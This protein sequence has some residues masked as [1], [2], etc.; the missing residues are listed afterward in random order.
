MNS[1]SHHLW[2]ITFY[3]LTTSHNHC[4]NGQKR[5][6]Q[7]VSSGKFCRSSQ[8]KRSKTYI[9]LFQRQQKTPSHLLGHKSPTT[10]ALYLICALWKKIMFIFSCVYRMFKPLSNTWF[11]ITRIYSSYQFGFLWNH[12]LIYSATNHYLYFGI[13]YHSPRHL[14][15][16]FLRLLNPMTQCITIGLVY[17]FLT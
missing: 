17:S 9:H 16:L 10:D 4:K 1:K 15:C 13:H 6:C 7:E 8:T 2:F 14:T 5:T 11:Q 12:S 3:Q